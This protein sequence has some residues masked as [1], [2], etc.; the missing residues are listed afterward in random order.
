M[1]MHEHKP[2]HFTVQLFRKDPLG[3]KPLRLCKRVVGQ[4]TAR[5]QE[6]SFEAQARAWSEDRELIRQARARGLPIA[7]PSSPLK[8]QDFPTF[9]ESAYVPW[10]RSN[11]EP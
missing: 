4:E 11:L 5:E 7:L 2:G 9:L 1:G 8:P 3:E 6:A 10:A